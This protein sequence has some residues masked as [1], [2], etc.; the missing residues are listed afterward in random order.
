MRQV[1]TFLLCA[2]LAGGAGVPVVL[3][4]ADEPFL[5][6]RALVDPGF[7]SRREVVRVQTG[8][9]SRVVFAWRL[10]K[11]VAHSSNVAR[12]KK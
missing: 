9:C 4:I 2:A 1:Y 8:G 3:A 10:L 5:A 11:E 7:D 6:A 12:C